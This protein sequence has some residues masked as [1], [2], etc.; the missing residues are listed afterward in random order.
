MKIGKYYYP[1]NDLPTL[2]DDVKVLYDEYKR[3][4][5]TREHIATKL[6]YSPKSGGF[7]QRLADFK[8][9]GLLDGRGDYH[10]TELAVKATYGTEKE[11]SESM[12]GAV[13]KIELWRSINAKWGIN[14]P[15]DT[16][17]IDLAEMAG[18][19]RSESK[20]E[21]E[22][23][24]KAYMDDAKYLLPVKSAPDN[25]DFQKGEESN[26]PGI[27]SNSACGI[28][29]K[30]ML[31]PG[32]IVSQDFVAYLGFPEYIEKPLIIKDAMS[33]GIAKELMKA[34]EGRINSTK[35]PVSDDTE[36][37]NS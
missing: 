37:T 10:V 9:Y 22:N 13:R 24:L 5:I 16:F 35:K 26:E 20:K 25:P 3:T 36:T 6:K 19:E 18:I 4:D 28:S 8:A 21:A 33:L 17:W 23:I 1:L 11:K 7:G 2:V 12:D 15:A 31:E 30:K 34:I 32:K 14:V 29:N 27:G